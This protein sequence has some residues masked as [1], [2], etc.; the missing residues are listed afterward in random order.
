HNRQRIK[1]DGRR[2]W[3]IK[4]G[5][6]EAYL[7]LSDCEATLWSSGGKL[8]DKIAVHPNEIADWSGFQQGLLVAGQFSLQWLEIVDLKFR[9]VSEL[10]LA[11][12]DFDGP[13]K[14]LQWIPQQAAFVLAGQHGQAAILQAKASQISLLQRL[15]IKDVTQLA[16]DSKGR[17]LAMAASDSSFAIWQ[18]Q[19][20]TWQL[21]LEDE[22][23]ATALQFASS[24]ANEAIQLLLLGV[25]G[26]L[27]TWTPGTS[28]KTVDKDG[29]IEIPSQGGGLRP[30]HSLQA[31]ADGHRGLI[32]RG[33]RFFQWRNVE[34]LQLE[35]V[36]ME[37]GF[38]WD[39]LQQWAID[40]CR[41]GVWM[42]DHES[43]SYWE[44]RSSDAASLVKL[45]EWST[46]PGQPVDFSSNCSR[47]ELGFASLDAKNGQL[48]FWTESGPALSLIGDTQ[49]TTVNSWWPR[50]EGGEQLIT[51]GFDGILRF[52]TSSAKKLTQFLGHK[53]QVTEV[54]WEAPYRLWLSSAEDASTRL[55]NERGEE[56]AKLD[57]ATEG[58]A[59]LRDAAIMGH[60]GRHI[61]ST[62]SGLLGF[63]QLDEAGVWNLESSQPISPGQRAGT[64]SLFKR[65]DGAILARFTRATD[66]PPSHSLKIFQENGE[67]W[68]LE[69]GEP[70][71]KQLLQLDIAA[72]G[73]CIAFMRAKQDLQIWRWSD[74]KWQQES[75]SL[76]EGLWS[77]LKQVYLSSD[78]Q[79]LL[80]VFEH[81]NLLLWRHHAGVWQLEKQRV[82]PDSTRLERGLR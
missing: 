42:Q 61:V 70:N 30:I 20:G 72:D 18:Y 24:T 69:E 49:E 34:P 60:D 21:V 28:W 80:T 81:K 23:S 26:R 71:L 53:G 73:S 41:G 57:L 7:A 66:Y 44:W 46:H 68:P 29:P 51:A 19:T 67:P 38:A 58:N 54:R 39:R 2:V 77:D 14:L 32:E 64:Q 47:E 25:D 17:F 9:L 10:N 8:L 65:A 45:A 63:W 82:L 48:R 59:N 56:I 78:A 52:W 37:G 15:D 27:H 4:L 40:A 31:F 75:I 76:P 74:A 1:G 33:G 62:G 11:S 6:E 12:L 35:L 16:L 55:W 22:R 3:A 36:R 13:P 5:A 79:E 43:I 50:P